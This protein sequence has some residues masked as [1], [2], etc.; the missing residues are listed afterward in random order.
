[1]AGV[2][3]FGAISEFIPGLT[4]Y[5]Y[6]MGNLHRMQYGRG[7][8]V[9]SQGAP[10]IKI[11]LQQLDHFVGFITSPHL[12]QDLPFGEENLETMMKD[13]LKVGKLYLKGDYKVFHLAF[14]Y[15]NK[16]MK[17]VIFSREGGGRGVGRR[18]EFEKF[19]SDKIGNHFQWLRHRS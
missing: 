11:H 16:L 4:Q 12:A 6:T 14:S 15:I 19:T 17:T 9:P 5:R 13:S 1:M 7:A 8:P 3:S 2:A 10:R 18:R